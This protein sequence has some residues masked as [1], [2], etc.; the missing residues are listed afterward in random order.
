MVLISRARAPAFR[1]LDKPVW[2]EIKV[3]I[4]AAIL[5]GKKAWSFSVGKVAASL[6]KSGNRSLDKNDAQV[7]INSG[8]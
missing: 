4:V 3:I 5:G 1:L 6:D 2:V 7:P 8:T